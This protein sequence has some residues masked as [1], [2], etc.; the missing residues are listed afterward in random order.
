LFL[1]FVMFFVR[2]RGDGVYIE[3]WVGMHFCINVRT[4]FNVSSAFGA[5]LGL[6]AGLILQYT[7]VSAC[8]NGRR[9][10]SSESF[11]VCHGHKNE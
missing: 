7:D 10:T 5:K 8:K 1:E 2:H 3:Y 6:S 11:L 9:R 4:A